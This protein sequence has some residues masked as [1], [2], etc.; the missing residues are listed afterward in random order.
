MNSQRGKFDSATNAARWTGSF[1]WAVF[2]ALLAALPA[3]A[4][5]WYDNFN[6][7]G[8]DDWHIFAENPEIESWEEKGGAAVGQIFWDETDATY[9]SGLQLK[10]KGEDPSGWENY[11]VR[12]RM[13]L[14]S[15]PRESDTTLFGLMVHDGLDDGLRYHMCLLHFQESK[16][17]FY[18]RANMDDRDTKEFPFQVKRKVWYTMTVKVETL[19][20]AEIVTVWIDDHDPV[21]VE[22]EKIGPGGPT[23]V[24]GDARVSF[25]D[26]KIEGA[27]IPNLPA[28]KAAQAWGHVKNKLRR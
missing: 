5:K 26:F 6:S 1:R 16:L 25:D 8:L 7:G 28:N 15:E 14:E 10:P 4:G 24:V 21:S 12:A 2:A 13:R 11:T 20:D 23:L 27:N 9:L 19:A 3:H 18:W 22:W 17:R